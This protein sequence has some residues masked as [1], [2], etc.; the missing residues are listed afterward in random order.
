M[1]GAVAQRRK[2][3]LGPS[4][5]PKVGH[6]KLEDLCVIWMH[7]GT[8]EAPLVPLTASTPTTRDAP[9]LSL[10]LKLFLRHTQRLPLCSFTF[11]PL[12]ES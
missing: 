7:L 4:K 5:P 9:P 11:A 6:D 2:K 12:L 1:K 8:C 10:A 3:G